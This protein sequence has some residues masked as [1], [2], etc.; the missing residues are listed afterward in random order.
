MPTDCCGCFWFING[1]QKLL[2]ELSTNYL[3]V[4]EDS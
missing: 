4:T 2:N 1:E 3:P